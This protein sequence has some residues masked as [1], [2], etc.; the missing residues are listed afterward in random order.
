MSAMSTTQKDNLMGDL[1]AVIQDTEELLKATASQAGE[2]TLALRE[3]ARLRLDKAKVN[4][5]HLQDAAIEK[6]KAAGHKTD[7][8][9]HDHPWQSVGVA[10]GIGLLLGMLISRR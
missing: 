9:V 3:R 6:A 7:D 5:Q 8:Y 2:S 1:N 4:L 10:A